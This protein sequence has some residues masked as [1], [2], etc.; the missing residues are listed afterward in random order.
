MPLGDERAC[1]AE[2][3]S[4]DLE[5]TKNLR[6]CDVLRHEPVR[7]NGR[8][9]MMERTGAARAVLSLAP[10][11]RLSF[12]EACRGAR[13]SA[14]R[15]RPD[16]AARGSG[17]EPADGL[18]QVCAPHAPARQRNGALPPEIPSAS[19]PSHFL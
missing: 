1:Y 5:D 10:C 17:G 7:G 3:F 15:R 16:V 11:A 19:V 9:P 8:A 14:A 18:T 6:E 2:K 12:D 4:L 13:V